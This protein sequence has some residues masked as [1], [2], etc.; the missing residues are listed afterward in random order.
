MRAR[1]SARSSKDDPRST[2]DVRVEET[3]AGAGFSCIRAEDAGGGVHVLTLARPRTL[4]A[5]SLAMVAELDTAIGELQRGDAGAIVITGEGRAFCSGA[6]VAEFPQ[7]LGPAALD[8]YEG[9]M[10]YNELALKLWRLDV[11]LVAA[12]N[13]PAVGGGASLAFL[14]DIRVMAS[15][16]YLQVLQ[17][18]RGIIPDMGI[19]YVLPRLVGLSRAL[20][21]MLLARRI[22]AADALE[23]G[24]ASEVVEDGDVVERSLLLAH[25]LA[26]G[27]RV[28]LA[29]TRRATY[30]ALSQNF[31]NALKFEAA[32]Q[33]LC[34]QTEDFQARLDAYAS[35]SAESLPDD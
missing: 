4:N 20:D 3:S 6:D 33:S 10:K 28:A 26:D 30:D 35:K 2:A 5:M 23:M 1:D 34:S 29:L 7:L 8:A 32:C 22:S 16:A 14:T 9:V 25:Q 19:T 17:T 12:I 11:P 13:G 24:L 18:D 31:E 21:A 27:S 15:N